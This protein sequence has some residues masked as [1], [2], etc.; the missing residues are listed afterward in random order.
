MKNKKKKVKRGGEK[1]IIQEPHYAKRT[2]KLVWKIC[3]IARGK[4]PLL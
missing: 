4:G 1:L 3:E 2:L